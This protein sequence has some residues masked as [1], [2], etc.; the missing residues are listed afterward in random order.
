M[1]LCLSSLNLMRGTGLLHQVHKH[2]D[3]DMQTLVEMDLTRYPSVGWT[4]LQKLLLRP[5][6]QR[7]RCIR[8]VVVAQDVISRCGTETAKWDELAYAMGLLLPTGLSYLSSVDL[9]SV[10]LHIRCWL[11]ENEYFWWMRR[12]YCCLAVLSTC[13]GLWCHNK[14]LLGYEAMVRALRLVVLPL[15]VVKR[16]AIQHYLRSHRILPMWLTMAHVT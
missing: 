15:I 8:E 7:S 12:R 9:G 10:D 11:T 16:R 13:E 6:F 5:W 4:A 3:M 1:K 14:S 2:L